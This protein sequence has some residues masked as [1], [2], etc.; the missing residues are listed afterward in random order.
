MNKFAI[1][2]A[3]IAVFVTLADSACEYKKTLSQNGLPLMVCFVFLKVRGDCPLSSQ[4]T[5]CTPKCLQD[6]ECGVVGG[7]CCPNLCNSKSCV[8]PK[9]GSSSDKYKGSTGGSSAS[10]TYC[11][12]VKCSSFEKCSSD[13]TTSRPKCVRA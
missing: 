5:T 4:V 6:T 10:G 11:G 7:I 12:N 1:T 2:F 9:T 3:L 8:R 13:K